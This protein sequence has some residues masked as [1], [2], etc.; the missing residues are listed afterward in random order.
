MATMD[1]SFRVKVTWRRRSGGIEGAF[2]FARIVDPLGV[3]TLTL[4]LCLEFPLSAP[5]HSLDKGILN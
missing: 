4:A 5:V 2:V 1:S 3:S